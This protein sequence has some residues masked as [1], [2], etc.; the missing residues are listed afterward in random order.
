MT[1]RISV[2]VMTHPDR[3][4]NARRLAES[5]PECRIA[6]V[7]DPVPDGPPGA[8][9]TAQRAWEA[10]PEDSTHHVVLQD[11]VEAVPNLRAHLEQVVASLPEHPICLFTEWAS[12]TAQAVRLGL[13]E[14]RGLI[15]IVDH[16]HTTQ[17]VILPA[18]T[19][20]AFTDHMR[21]PG[22]VTVDSVADADLL[23][24]FLRD[25]GD[26]PYI[27]APNLVEHIELPSLLGNDLLRGPRHSPCFD[28]LPPERKWEVQRPGALTVI[29]HFST[30]GRSYCHFRSGDRWDRRQTVDVL[31]DGGVS[32]PELAEAYTAEMAKLDGGDEVRATA[33]DALVFQLWVTAVASGLVLR[34]R[35]GL[36]AEALD[37]AL[38]DRDASRAW[39]TLTRG[40]LRKTFPPEAGARLGD[41][42]APLVER[43]LLGAVPL[44][45]RIDHP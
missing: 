37:R 20:R 15:E 29:P 40:A 27:T 13:L 12:K 34:Q 26:L 8:V 5:Q 19:V 39:S 28:P 43:A 38:R 41:L 31:V 45:V 21:Q 3:I 10:M 2:V 14:G 42:L 17:G 35:H 24:E 7:T 4:E 16:L 9:R 36:G 25:R 30:E 44:D 32:V 6:I 23:F 22:V 18:A 11:D 1:P 33:S